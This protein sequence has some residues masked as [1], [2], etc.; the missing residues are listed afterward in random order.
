MSKLTKNQIDEL[1]ERGFITQVIPSDSL[2]DNTVDDLKIKELVTATDSSKNIESAVFVPVTYNFIS[3]GN[4][5]G[6]VVYGEG[7]VETTGVTNTY[8]DIDYTEVIVVTNTVPEWIGRKFY[9]DSAAVPDAIYQLL[10]DSG[11]EIDVW[12]K[13]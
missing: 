10:D 6:T 13:L 3:Y 4:P 8:N 9:I 11:V 2:A 12:V 1:K 7:T 5:E